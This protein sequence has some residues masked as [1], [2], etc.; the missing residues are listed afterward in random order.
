VL[1]IVTKKPAEFTFTPGQAIALSINKSGWENEVR[2]FTFTSIPENNF[3]EFIIKIYPSH[4]GVTNELLQL[5]KDD[6]IILHNIF[7]AEL[8]EMLSYNFIN[9]L[10]DENINGYA[11]GFISESLLKTHISRS[12]QNI[13]LCGPPQMME[14]VAKHLHYLNIDEKAIIKEEF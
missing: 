14:S 10:A 11:H 1:R 12:C 4:K 8:K 3:L 9:I 7:G 6:E 2:P 13:Y 5:T